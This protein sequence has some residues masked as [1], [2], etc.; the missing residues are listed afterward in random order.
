MFLGLVVS[1]VVGY[2]A[3]RLSLC[4]VRTHRVTPSLALSTAFRLFAFIYLV[5]RWACDQACTLKVVLLGQYVHPVSLT[6][7]HC[8][9]A[10]GVKCRMNQIQEMALMQ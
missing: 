3:V 4:L 1:A 8:M 6:L 5:R 9:S 10:L 2:S 7:I